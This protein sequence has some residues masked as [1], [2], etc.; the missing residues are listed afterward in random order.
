MTVAG[1]NNRVIGNTVSNVFQADI[2]RLFGRSNVITGNVAIG[3]YPDPASGFHMDIIQT[4]GQNGRGSQGHLIANNIFLDMPG[5]QVAQLEPDGVAEIGDW[6]FQNNVFRG[7]G[8]GSSFL[9]PGTRIVNNIFINC[10]TNLGGQPLNIGIDIDGGRADRCVV[11]NNIFIDNG[12]SRKTVGWYNI[13]RGLTGVVADFNYVSKHNYGSV[14]SGTVP[15]GSGTHDNF[16][17]YEP[18]GVNGGDPGFQAQID[19]YRLR[20]NSILIDRGTVASHYAYDADGNSRPQGRTWDIGPFEATTTAR[21]PS[22]PKNVT[23]R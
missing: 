4:F 16:A 17:F 18:H 13:D 19:N 10:N 22:P 5:C 2:F 8:M 15:V 6:T 7:I 23:T 20:S 3:N 12:D 14:Q 11:H 1:Q 9:I 21:P